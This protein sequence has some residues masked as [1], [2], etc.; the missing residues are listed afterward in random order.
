MNNFIDSNERVVVHCHAG[1]SRSATAVIAYLMKTLKLDLEQ[2]FKFV[3]SKRHVVCPNF[4]FMGQ[5]RSYQNDLEMNYLGESFLMIKTLPE[6]QR[7]ANLV[8][9]G[10][11][12]AENK[13]RKQ[14]VPPLFSKLELIREYHDSGVDTSESS[15]NESPLGSPKNKIQRIEFQNVNIEK[16]KTLPMQI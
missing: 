12:K 14:V 10:D 11:L 15:P 4:S 2:A 1:I 9:T 6:K 3:Q 13:T 16:N 8:V 7:Q 5:L